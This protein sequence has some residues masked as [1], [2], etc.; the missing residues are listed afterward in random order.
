MNSQTQ[1]RKRIKYVFDRT[2][3]FL[4]AEYSKPTNWNNVILFG[5]SGLILLFLFGSLV[6]SQPVHRIDDRP[7]IGFLSPR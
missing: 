1:S 6:V 3:R 2:G 5:L 4:G 7:S